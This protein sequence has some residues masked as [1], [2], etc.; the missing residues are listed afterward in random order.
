MPEIHLTIDKTP[1]GRWRLTGPRVVIGR[2][3]NCDIALD[4]PLSSRRHAAIFQAADGAFVIED[5]GSK[6]G[7]LVNGTRIQRQALKH[8][9]IVRIGRAEAVYWATDDIAPTPM[10]AGREPSTVGRDPSTIV[11]PARARTEIAA[12]EHEPKA[13][14]ESATKS[15]PTNLES[16]DVAPDENHPARLKRRIASLEEELRAR[17]VE[18][19]VL[20]Q[21]IR[22]RTTIAEKSDF[23][24][25]GRGRNQDVRLPARFSVS[26]GMVAGPRFAFLAIGPRAKRFCAE[27]LAQGHDQVYFV[28]STGTSGIYPDREIR[29]PELST[30][31]WS[32]AATQTLAA[33]LRPIFD[34]ASRRPTDF[35][36]VGDA[37]MLPRSDDV[38][39][40]LGAVLAAL[41][42]RSDVRCAAHAFLFLA[43][44]SVGGQ[45]TPWTADPASGR[46][47]SIVFCDPAN[48]FV[49][50]ESIARSR[51]PETAGA[52]LATVLNLVGVSA[53]QGAFSEVELREIWAGIGVTLGT[54]VAPDLADE[55]IEQLLSEIVTTAMTRPAAALADQVCAAWLWVVDRRFLTQPT[56]ADRLVAT[57]QKWT[58]IALPKAKATIAVFAGHECGIRL[59]TASGGVRR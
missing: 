24:P 44:E 4:D 58:R 8:G 14:F 41:P 23:S 6:N 29:C 16:T 28:E 34:D 33:A 27:I 57:T 37:E 51:V 3:T 11:S 20:R 19:G 22:R 32:P 2:D 36:I 35:L 17:D 1:A 52:V 55:S 47:A 31:G 15:D 5:L 53:V 13:S 43:P 46:L 39:R 12:G 21:G 25:G 56:V 50:S 48:A 54:N 38:E 59:F 49:S 40:G 18:L 42:Q 7:V 30:G 10:P 26:S 45:A 9:D